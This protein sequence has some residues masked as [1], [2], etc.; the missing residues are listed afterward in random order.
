VRFF[1]L[2][3][4]DTAGFGLRLVQYWCNPRRA[5]AQSTGEASS[6]NDGLIRAFPDKNEDGH[7]VK[8]LVSRTLAPRQSGSG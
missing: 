4:L 7:V 2:M 5:A 1:R 8:W 3:P 6:K